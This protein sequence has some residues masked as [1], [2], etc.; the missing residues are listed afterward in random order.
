MWINFRGKRIGLIKDNH[1]PPL[2]SER[3]GYRKVYRFLGLKLIINKGKQMKYTITYMAGNEIRETVIHGTAYRIDQGRLEIST[4][5]SD[6][7]YKADPGGPCFILPERLLIHICLGDT[8]EGIAALPAQGSV[9]DL[10]GAIVEKPRKSAGLSPGIQE[11][12]EDEELAFIQ[13]EKDAS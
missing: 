10:G 2:F 6:D 7:P 9:A 1:Q 12:V 4:E 3:Y 13:G 8:Q 5:A 11:K